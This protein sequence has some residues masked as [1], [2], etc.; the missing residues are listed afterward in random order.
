MKILIAN[1]GIHAHYYE[2]LA[3][4][5]AFNA[6]GIEARMYDVKVPAFGIFD[7]YEPDIFIGQL[8]NLDRATIK[9]IQARPHLKVALRSGEFNNKE[10]NPH[11]LSVGPE[12]LSQLRTLQDSTGKPDFIFSYYLQKD[13][14]QTHEGFSK[15]GIKL[16][17]IPMSADVHTYYHGQLRPELE[18]DIAF[19][20]GYWPYKAQ[21]LDIFLLPI[22]ADF[23][24]NVKIFGNQMWPHTN[25][26]SGVIADDLVRVLFVSA[27]ICPN[28]SEPHSQQYGIDVNERAFKVLAAGGFCIM[29]N[30]RAAREI[31]GHGVVFADSPKEFRDLIQYYLT[32]PE[33]RGKI[34]KAGHN[35][36]MGAHTNY[37]RAALFM[38]SFN[39]VQASERILNAY[40]N[41]FQQG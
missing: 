13:I 41:H 7:S 35:I 14:D 39:E 11:I 23:R 8:Y 9:C 16:V 33:E 19:V 22:L 27:K 17:G 3:W 18:C 25:Q 5:N 37:H 10:K 4:C 24:Y 20:G 30:V 21:V 38:N 29:D 12:E 31:F 6:S 1:D 36:V 34:S 26:Y 28:L 40:N 32:Q 2:R 15:M